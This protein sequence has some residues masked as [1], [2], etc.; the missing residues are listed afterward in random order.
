MIDT[1]FI[2]VTDDLARTLD[3]VGEELLAKGDLRGFQLRTLV[4]AWGIAKV[5]Q[6]PSDSG[7]SLRVDD[8][9]SVPG[10]AATPLRLVTGGG[11]E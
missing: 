9:A 2:A 7:Q 8:A 4:L 6:I 1:R 3:E 5:Q 10:P 11:A